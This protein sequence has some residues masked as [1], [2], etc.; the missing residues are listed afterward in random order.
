MRLLALWEQKR[1]N[2]KIVNWLYELGGEMRL[3]ELPQFKK[4]YKNKW[5]TRNSPMKEKQDILDIELCHKT[6][7]ADYYI[8]N[9]VDAD[10]KEHHYRMIDNVKASYRCA[11]RL[12]PICETIKARQEYTRLTWKMN[13]VKD[14]YEFFFLTLTLP[15]VHTKFDHLLDRMNLCAN[16]LLHY[17]GFVNSGKRQRVEGFYSTWEVTYSEKNGFHPHL[18]TIIA[19]PKEYVKEVQETRQKKQIKKLVLQRPDVRSPWVTSQYDLV[20]KYRQFL[21]SNFP[22]AYPKEDYDYIHLDFRKCYNI[23]NDVRELC[24]YFI[25]FTSLPTKEAFIVYAQ[26]VYNKKRKKKSGCFKWTEENEAEWRKFIDQLHE[27]QKQSIV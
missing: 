26:S 10:G 19:I 7:A 13:Q 2:L 11:S 16:R 4:K 21:E 25:D 9:K 12:C 14:K 24:K 23:D 27:E 5:V 8:E 17:M 22:G 1:E 20:E 15:N 18:H 6:F 3:G